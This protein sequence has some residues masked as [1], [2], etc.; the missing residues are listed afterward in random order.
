MDFG[1]EIFHFGIGVLIVFPRPVD[2]WKC[3][4]SFSKLAFFAALSFPDRGY[5]SIYASRIPSF[6]LLT[7]CLF[8]GLLCLLRLVECQG[9]R[10][11][12]GQMPLQ[13]RERERM[14]RGC[15]Y[16]TFSWKE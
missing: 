12:I 2:L 1:L 10:V 5:L 11:D 15:R 13:R 6:F 4:S 16:Y 7:V 9:Q 14:G 8:V 3:R